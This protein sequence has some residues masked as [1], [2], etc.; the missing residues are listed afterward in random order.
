LQHTPDALKHFRNRSL[1]QHAR[2][3]TLATVVLDDRRG[4]LLVNLHAVT[5]DFFGV[6]AAAFLPRALRN[7]V[8]DHLD[9]D[10]DEKRFLDRLAQ[11]LEHLVQGFG[12]G[13]VARVAVE[14]EALLDVWLGQALFQ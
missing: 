1:A 13:Q 6:V 9:I 7:A 8:D 3:Q 5:R 14:D 4:S 12:L 11:A 2:Q 10:V